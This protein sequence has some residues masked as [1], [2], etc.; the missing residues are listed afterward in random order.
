MLLGVRNKFAASASASD[1][2]FSAAFSYSSNPAIAALRF[3]RA[4]VVSLLAATYNL[5]ASS[6]LVCSASFTYAFQSDYAYASFSDY[7]FTAFYAASF[8]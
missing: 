6:F 2:A 8:A 7:S 3:S 5:Y 4:V 1:F